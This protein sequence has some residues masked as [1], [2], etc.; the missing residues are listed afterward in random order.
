VF[1]LKVAAV[2]GSAPLFVLL[3]VAA[4]EGSALLFVFLASREEE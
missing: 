3:K 1:L 2:E 4:V